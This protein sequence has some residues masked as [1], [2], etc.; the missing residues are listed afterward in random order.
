MFSGTY[1]FYDI[2]ANL[3]VMRAVAQGR[4]PCRPSHD[5]SQVR[6]LNAE[7]WDLI[8]TCW[9]T[10]P[11]ERP[12]S[13]QIVEQLRALPDRPVDRRPVDNFNLSF[14]SQVLQNQ[15]NHPFSALAGCIEDTDKTQ[16]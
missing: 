1:P 14:S 2:K 13:G 8:N 3:L 6:G 11:S 4:R 9:T 5:L 7:I 12:S 16:G 15:V 10:E